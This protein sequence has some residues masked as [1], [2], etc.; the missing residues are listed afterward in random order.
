LSKLKELTIA[1]DAPPGSY[2]IAVG[3]YDLPTLERLSVTDHNG[4]LLPDARILIAGPEVLQPSLH[5]LHVVWGDV[6]LLRGYELQHSTELLKL[7]LNW[8]AQR[9][10]DVSYKVFV[11]L[12]DVTTGAIAAQDDAV[13]CR[14]TYP[15]TCWERGEVVEDTIPLSLSGVP[16]GR[17]RLVLGLYDQSAGE[18]LPAYSADGVQYPDN[19]VPLTTVQH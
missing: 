17:Y 3:M 2:Q 12:V 7:T 11:H 5:S 1:P 16:P 10:M 6:I 13:P 9:R 15:T 4:A 18:R 8:Q 19:A 14:W